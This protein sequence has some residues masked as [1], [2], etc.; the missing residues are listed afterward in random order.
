VLPKLL[1]LM[2]DRGFEGV[3][4]DQTQRRPTNVGEEQFARR[5]LHLD[6]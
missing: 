1:D 4:R 2:M 5:G 3:T 6:A